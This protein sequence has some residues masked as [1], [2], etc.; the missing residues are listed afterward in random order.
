MA[1]ISEYRQ[2]TKDLVKNVLD[3]F[4]DAGIYLDR[5]TLS[6]LAKNSQ[7][8]AKFLKNTYDYFIVFLEWLQ[9]EIEKRKTNDKKVLE[10]VDHFNQITKNLVSLRQE[11]LN[12]IPNLKKI[13]MEIPGERKM[14]E[15]QKNFQAA[16]RELKVS[17]TKLD[18]LL[19]EDKLKE[20]L[21]EIEERL[22]APELLLPKLR[23]FSR[24][25]AFFIGDA[26]E[27]VQ[28]QQL[29]AA[30]ELYLK[31]L[32]K[33]SES[34]AQELS[35]LLLDIRGELQIW[36]NVHKNVKKMTAE[37]YPQLR[38]QL[39]KL[40]QDDEKMYEEIEAA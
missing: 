21:K 4:V 34:V 18:Y 14:I 8:I 1:L 20:Y 19:E 10:I 13:E 26:F 15:D 40:L 32:A 6:N 27:E 2:E 24:S 22:F 39:L 7:V 17:Y 35:S 37:N 3:W 16:K 5:M 29:L 9:E 36:K 28:K 33:L 23:G 38:A 25:I 31:E 30:I 12:L 11:V